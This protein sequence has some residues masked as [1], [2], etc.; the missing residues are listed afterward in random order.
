MISVEDVTTDATRDVA[1]TIMMA[2]D[3][4]MAV[5]V[6]DRGIAGRNRGGPGCNQGNGHGD[7]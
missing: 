5:K 2:K 4:V 3:M 7:W 6:Q 1:T